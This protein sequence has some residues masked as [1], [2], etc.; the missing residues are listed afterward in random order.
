MNT[1]NRFQR[2]VGAPVLRRAA[3]VLAMAGAV[4][5]GLA[6]A[7]PTVEAPGVS[8]APAPAA[9]GLGSLGI[10]QG[11]A[12]QPADMLKLAPQGDSERSFVFRPGVPDTDYQT[13]AVGGVVP[14]GGGVKLKAAAGASSAGGVVGVG[15]SVPW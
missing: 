8:G 1:R 13:N 15:V 6:H 12:G 11:R 10:R 14:L 4:A 2:G 7:Q 9:T 3:L 5:S